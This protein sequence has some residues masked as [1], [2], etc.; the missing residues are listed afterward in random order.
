MTRQEAIAARYRIAGQTSLDGRA[1]AS[2]NGSPGGCLYVDYDAARALPEAERAKLHH[3]DSHAGMW[4]VCKRHQ[5]SKR[6][7]WMH[8]VSIDAIIGYAAAYDGAFPIEPMRKL[9]P[10]THLEYRP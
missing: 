10:R 9:L 6:H 3:Y 2:C 5:P 7:A 8:D 1:I 4:R